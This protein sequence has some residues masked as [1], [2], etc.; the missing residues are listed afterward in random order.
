[1]LV[2]ALGVSLSH[3]PRAS[4]GSCAEDAGNLL[5]FGTMQPGNPNAFGVIAKKWRG[6]VIGGNVPHFEIADNEGWDPY[7]SQ[8]IWRDLGAWDAG[9]FQKKK[10]LVPGQTYHFWM[11]WGQAL[12]DMQ[13]DR[14]IGVDLTGG[15]DPTAPTVQW[16]VPYFGGGGF[17]R[18]EWSLYFTAPSSVAT[19]FLRAQ[20]GHTDGRN[21]VFFD[22][23]CL[24]P[25][26]GEPTTTP[27]TTPAVT[28]TP[29]ATP[30]LT[31]TATPSPSPTLTPTPAPGYVEDTNADIFYNVLWS[32]IED[33]QASAGTYHE[34]RGQKGISANLKYTFT[35]TEITVRYAAGPNRGK[36]Q[37]VIDGV[38]MGKIDQYAPETTF[39]LTQT[40]SNLTPGT[41]L[42]K[43]KNAGGKHANSTDSI[44][45]LDAFQ[46]PAEAGRMM[47]QK[48]VGQR[49]T[50]TPTVTRAGK[51]PTRVAPR[52]IPFRM[53][54]P[55]ADP[56]EDPNVIWD[57]RL[58]GLNVYL[59]PAD[60]PNGT[61]YWK[62]IRLDYHDPFQHGGDF[63]A[64]HNMYYV[65]TDQNGDRV[66]GQKVWQSWP[67]D[68]T[69][70]TTDG[71]GI[72]DI[73]MWAN[74]FPDHGPGPYNGYVD[75]L[76]SD[77]VRGMGLPANNHVSFIMYF[78]KAVKGGAGAPTATPT[79]T[80][81][82][83]TPTSPTPTATQP[84]TPATVID[85]TDPGIW[86]K[87]GGWQ[88]SSDAQAYNNSLHSGRGAKGSPVVLLYDFTG[89]EVTVRYVGAPNHGKINVVIDGIKRG[90]IDTRTE[91]TTYGLGRTFTVPPG[92]HRVK[93]KNAG[94]KNAL[95]N[96]TI[97]YVDALEIR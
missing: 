1:M 87:R 12:H 45:T 15:T 62:L 89:T 54:E 61:L 14:Q 26:T 25:A 18:P 46:L 4:A 36:A 85:D 58:P 65:I 80:S 53:A 2:S 83:P 92:T 50:A 13:G 37:V 79:A 20:N 11:I 94:A 78:Q 67:D 19:F 82:P 39:G 44:I 72:T 59:V 57:S 84:T 88:A 33:G 66:S 69:S 23:V 31:P 48:N 49:M 40:F 91:T 10:N 77:E 63:G 93:I 28:A 73:A 27:W 5:K 70:A 96:D 41:H 8:Y 97:I 6:F 24:Y 52:L 21:K 56:P 35:G 90:K 16:T 42:V 34:A 95:S 60:V 81:T 47:L 43:I 9:I 32:Q 17:N 64:D 68:K 30:T 74:Y 22:A 71:R 38:K 7:G 75:G 29:T 3:P 76:P 86:Y 51:S 55:G